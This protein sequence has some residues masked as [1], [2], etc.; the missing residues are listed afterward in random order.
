MDL[1]EKLPTLEDADLA[2][3]HGN[4]ER[5]QH[6]GTSAQKKA[7]AALLPALESELANR[8]AAKQA[9]ATAKRANSRQATSKQAAKR[10]A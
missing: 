9:A 3:L 6:S 1:I 2:A 5:L 7:A 10:Q 4:A 8:R